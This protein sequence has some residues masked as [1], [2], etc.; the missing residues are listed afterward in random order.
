MEPLGMRLRCSKR[1]GE[2][3]EWRS[4]KSEI[5]SCWIMF[6]L[7]RGLSLGIKN[8][9]LARS[10]GFVECNMLMSITKEK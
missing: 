5:E 3:I 9:I 1:R 4:K 10:L 8:V 6:D 2:G 7:E